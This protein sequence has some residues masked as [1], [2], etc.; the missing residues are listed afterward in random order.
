MVQVGLRPALTLQPRPV[1]RVLAATHL[2]S[3]AMPSRPIR[4]FLIALLLSRVPRH[5]LVARSPCARC[6]SERWSNARAI[7]IRPGLQNDSADALE[8]VGLELTRYDRDE[9]LRGPA[10]PRSQR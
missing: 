2:D 9:P 7:S 6:S 8:L 10:T 1:A 5:C 3:I 4:S